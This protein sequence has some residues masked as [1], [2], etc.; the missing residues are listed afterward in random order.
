M[1][2][3][4]INTVWHDSYWLS[5]CFVA[6]WYFQSLLLRSMV[7]CITVK[8]GTAIHYVLRHRLNSEIRLLLLLSSPIQAYKNSPAPVWNFCRQTEDLITP[9]WLKCCATTHLSKVREVFGESRRAEPALSCELRMLC[10]S[11][12]LCILRSWACVS[13]SACC[14]CCCRRWLLEALGLPTVTQHSAGPIKK[15]DAGLFYGKFDTLDTFRVCV[16]V[17]F[18]FFF[19]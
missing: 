3:D 14:C 12:W 16:R 2:E 19:N 4:W 18:F 7:V 5:L 15:R 6:K 1:C 17:C 9:D 11:F 10:R 8:V 13:T